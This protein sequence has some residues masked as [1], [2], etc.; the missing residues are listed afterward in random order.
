MK[1][2]LFDLWVL[3]DILWW[4]IYIIRIWSLTL[5]GSTQQSA[6][7]DPSLTLSLTQEAPE[8]KWV[9][10]TMV[11]DEIAALTT[12]SC[13]V[14]HQCTMGNG[15]GGT[16]RT[17]SGEKP[18][19]SHLAADEP[20]LQFLY[21][22]LD[23]AVVT[24]TN[25]FLSDFKINH[26][27]RLWSSQWRVLSLTVTW[28][29]LSCL[30]RRSGPAHFLPIIRDAPTG[31]D[32]T[33]QW[34]EGAIGAALGTLQL[35]PAGTWMHHSLTVKIW[36]V[37]VNTSQTAACVCVC[38]CVR[39]CQLACRVLCRRLYRLSSQ[40]VHTPA[41]SAACLQHRETTVLKNTK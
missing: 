20:T 8:R 7:A 13:W 32:I 17:W 26:I 14:A 41:C 30:S 2:N 28:W 39:T 4:R 27:I 36:S 23:A 34:E 40:R 16:Q 19:S 31:S 9:L 5:T 3:E 25:C 35:T 21:W 22:P 11:T 10:V 18:I 24:L 12:I 15:G 6:V 33:L 1:L 37:T 29:C 38:V